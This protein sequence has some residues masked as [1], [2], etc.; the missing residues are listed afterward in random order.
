MLGSLTT[1]GRTVARGD[2]AVRVAFRVGKDARNSR[3][4]THWALSRA[5]LKMARRTLPLRGYAAFAC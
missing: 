4:R 5:L 2:A 1:P 3:E